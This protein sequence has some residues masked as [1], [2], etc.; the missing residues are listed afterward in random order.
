MSEHKCWASLAIA[1][2]VG[3]YDEYCD[4]CGALI[5]RTATQHPPQRKRYTVAGNIVLEDEPIGPIGIDRS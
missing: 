5:S 4:W 2:N 3:G 1:N